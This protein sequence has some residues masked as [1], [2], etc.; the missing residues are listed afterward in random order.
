[1]V[2]CGTT[3]A[4]TTTDAT[5]V[6]EPN[7]CGPTSVDAPGK[8]YAF[9]GNGFEV[10][11]DLC[12]APY[13]AKMHVYRGSCASLVCIDS[14]DDDCGNDPS[15]TFLTQVGQ[16]YYIYVNG[17]SGAT[18]TYSLAVTCNTCPDPDNL[19]LAGGTDTSVTLSWT[20][21]GVTTSAIVEYGP[22]GFTP[23]TGTEVT[24]NSNPYTVM[25]LSQKSGYDFYVK[26]ICN[27]DTTAQIGPVFTVTGCSIGDCV[28]DFRLFD[29]E[30]DGWDGAE[31]Q[32]I[33]DG[34]TLATITLN[35]GSDTTISIRL[36]RASILELRWLSGSFDSEI[37]FELVDAVGT[38]VYDFTTG[39]AP[40]DGAV[41]L[42]RA[43]TCP[44]CAPPSNLTATNVI[45]T[46]ATL[47]WQSGGANGTF[48]LEYGPENFI[49]GNGITINGVVAP[50]VLQG[51]NG[52]TRYDFYVT[53][54][55]TVSDTSDPRGP[56]TFQTSP[57]NNECLNAIPLPCNLPIFGT[58]L[59]ATLRGDLIGGNCGTDI[60][61][62]G[63]WYSAIGSGAMYTVS[64][65][66]NA[67][68]DTKISV[69]RGGCGSL[70]CLSGNDDF[71]GCSGNTSQASWQS[72]PDTMYYIFVHGFADEVGN[73]SITLSSELSLD[74]G[75]DL[76]LCVGEIDT[77]EGAAGGASYQWSTG[78]STS[79]IEIMPLINT[80][81]SVTA[82]DQNGCEA[83]DTVDVVVNSIPLVNAGPDDTICL[84]ESIV[85]TAT[86]GTTYAWSTGD[87]AAS[88][89]V[90]PVADSTFIVTVTGAN[91]CSNADT[92]NITVLPVP[93]ADAGDNDTICVGETVVLTATG[94]GSYEW[95]TGAITAAISVSPSSTTTYIITVTGANF[96]TNVDSATVIVDPTPTSTLND[97]SICTGSTVVLD[98]GNVGAT[99]DWSTGASSQVIP[100]SSAGTYIVTVT[101]PSGC[102]IIDTSVVT[103]GNTLTVILDDPIICP[104]ETAVLNAGNPGAT[105][106]WS[107][108][109]PKQTLFVTVAGDYIVTVTD[110]NGC[111]GTDTATLTVLPLPPADAGPTTLLCIGESTTLTATG[112]GTY[113]WSTG[114]NTDTTT[115]SPIVDT[116]YTVTVTSA[117]GCTASD[118]VLVD[119]FP[120]PVVNVSG[121]TSICA[122]ESV[123]LSATGAVNYSWSTGGNTSSIT[124]SPL[125]STI[126]SVT[127][128]NG[129]GCSSSA[130]VTVIVNVPI[131]NAGPDTSVCIGDSVMIGESGLLFR[132]LINENF[133]GCMLPSGW[134]NFNLNVGGAVY[135]FDSLGY[136]NS[137]IDGTCMA[138]IDDD[139]LPGGTPPTNAFLVTPTVDADGFTSLILEADINY[140][141]FISG[142]TFSI[143]VFDGALWVTVL[144]WNEDHPPS[145]LGNDVSEAINVDISAYAN[146]NLAIRFHY[147]D[148]GSDAWMVHIDNVL[149]SGVPPAPLTYSW[150]PASGLSDASVPDPKASPASTTMY[151]VTATDSLGCS[152]SDT[153][154]VNV[155]PLPVVTF[156]GLGAM[157]CA[158]E[159]AVQLTGNPGGGSFS[160]SGIDMDK[161]DPSMANVGV[162]D[163][164]YTYTDGNGCMASDTQSVEVKPLPTVSFTGLP[165][166]VCLTD[167][168]VTLTG[169]PPGG[170]F[171]GAVVNDTVFDPQ[172][173]GI[174]IHSVYYAYTD[175]SGCADTARRIIQVNPG[176]NV[177]FATGT[178]YCEDDQSTYP[179]V[180][181][182]AGGTFSGPGVIG[183]DF[184]PSIAGVGI[185]NIIYEVV[186]TAPYRVD[187]ACTF[188]LLTS[189]NQMAVNLPDQDEELSTPIAIGFPFQF[190]GDTYTHLLV[191]TNGFITFDTSSTSP[192]FTND[193]IPDNSGASDNLIALMWDDL[194]SPLVTYFE[195]GVAPNRR[196]VIYYADAFQFGN[197]AETVEGQIILFEGTNAIELHCA[198]CNK[199]ADDATATQGIENEDG[200]VAVV[201]PGRNNSDWDAFNDCVRFIPTF[202]PGADTLIVTVG[203]SPVV[204]VV[205]DSA[206]CSGDSTILTATGGSTYSW[207]TGDPTA[208]IKVAP[209]V[210]TD[211]IVTVTDVSGCISLDTTTVVVY[212]STP[213]NAGADTAL[214]EGDSIT[215]TATGAI[216]SY[217]WSN[218][219]NTASTTVSPLT[220]TTYIVTGTDANGCVTTD[221]I[222]V[223]VSP[224]PA[225]NLPDP[226]IC[227]GS[228][229]VLNAGNP[230]A[231]YLWSNSATTQ[232]ITVNNGGDFSVTVTSIDGC[233]AIDTARVSLGNNLTVNLV[234]ASFCPGDSTTLDAGNPGA[235]YIW[236]TGETTQTISVNAAGQYS[237]TATDAGGCVGSDTVTISLFAAPVINLPDPTICVGSSTV[238]DAGNAG[239]TYSWSTGAVTRSITV[240]T[241]GVYSV[242]VTDGNGCSSTDDATVTTGTSLT[243][244][245]NDV[246]ICQG[247][248]AVLDANN[249]NANYSWSNSATTQTITV[250]ASGTYSVTVT[251]NNNCV[252][253][254]TATVTVNPL[255]T[256]NAGAD[257]D[258]CEGDTE[259]LTATGGVSY[260]WSNGE[261]TASI[262]VTPSVTTTYSVTVT[263][264]NG[265]TDTDD[266][267][268][269][270]DPKPNADAGPDGEICIGDDFTTVASG[271]VSY[272]WSTGD[273]TPSISETP[274]TNTS[275]IV[276]VTDAN[277]CTNTDTVA[278]V[279]NPLPIPTISG[280]GDTTVC[281]DAPI[282]TISVTPVGGT[283]SGNGVTNGQFDPTTA[284]VGS[285]II[286]YTVTDSNGCA[287]A[288]R[289][290]IEVDICPGIDE[291]TLFNAVNVYPNPFTERIVI[292]LHVAEVGEMEVRLVDITGKLILFDTYDAVKGNNQFIMQTGDELSAGL[293]F[294]ELSK[295]GV[296]LPVKLTRIR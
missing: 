160:G 219:A 268:V 178:Q 203:A 205:S 2:T 271:G 239:A 173:S 288:V 118:S 269:N 208:S 156:S 79:A 142:D 18:G 58:T 193:T 155:N 85:L 139:G 182:P 159:P 84:G 15:I 169:T 293:Y 42:N 223:V 227:A 100:V 16:T 39:N 112:G 82:T 131:V 47:N 21:T 86:G 59:G 96:C 252:G 211:Y 90:S 201:R 136:S 231:A 143:D 107:T 144:K 151:I 148:A 162:N 73:F 294:I 44:T 187:T 236:S 235:T 80:T 115:V 283:L 130:T 22:Q 8:W 74:L 99:Y 184:A 45:D 31:M 264:A 9:M 270:V 168:P 234:G 119:V 172:V 127:G 108:G 98:A 48:I 57:A 125:V 91:G 175:P 254:D 281:V 181:T 206:I 289:D 88:I 274:A 154:M 176:L 258:I 165:T 147:D 251:D 4:G 240:S 186:P 64:T 224:L 14:E 222:E 34:D 49:P 133:D 217:A 190:F 228:S 134:Q 215:L 185:H 257:G 110:G 164:I 140:Q 204:T 273:V 290:T 171:G 295:D 272:N 263:D 11:T 41:F 5:D 237:V 89:N 63:V 141:N 226:T 194:E 69:F 53:E 19:V 20:S 232:T 1:M 174:G 260:E 287:G 152:A 179:L 265:C 66:G 188:G 111:T 166:I 207:S 97:V 245:L 113:S 24:A 94:G 262:N 36:C 202:C 28:Y 199:D 212:P 81:Y 29:D 225:I 78:Q 43:S 230:G 167:A 286:T 275:Y 60:D 191:S 32:V 183:G 177:Q 70:F 87:V 121:D 12:G 61:T 3:V 30:D 77:L 277:G 161:F 68:F 180:A 210:N 33:Q 106:Q 25:G 93:V 102:F 65:C 200:T 218:G 126:Y 137:T 26:E 195:T 123:T 256:A 129:A 153:V 233:I 238:L 291:Q 285:H 17:Y 6:D 189:P 163:I 220:T 216:V 192:D 170:T 95:S 196:F 209:T 37:S 221:S 280:I 253:S 132:E 241:D 51:L 83:S 246:V 158:N 71:T 242:T 276:T 116:W 56:V 198:G 54:V 122:G 149:L 50:Y 138:F 250:T 75:P 278:V 267:T 40:S 46:A 266:V 243:V 117:N 282:I 213:V 248:S 214:C 35:D 145:G 105:Y 27:T 38:I 229:T 249:P 10:T 101:D 62:A 296:T 72:L 255:P 279:V 23:G 52:S 292:D 244:G 261:T 55:C 114:D 135:S 103:I 67:D 109:S 7:S 128:S 13:D 284:G 104:G 92:V 76:T 259:T 150:L 120:I 124:V 157:Y 197:T 146:S 247:D